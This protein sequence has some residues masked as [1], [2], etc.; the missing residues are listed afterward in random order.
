MGWTDFDLDR[1]SGSRLGRVLLV[2]D[3]YFRGW[4]RLE[5]LEA[6]VVL[7]PLFGPWRRIAVPVVLYRRAQ[8]QFPRIGAPTAMDWLAPSADPGCTAAATLAVK[9]SA[10][11]KPCNQEPKSKPAEFCNTIHSQ[12][13]IGA[14]QELCPLWASLMSDPATGVSVSKRRAWQVRRLR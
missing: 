9:E 2:E 6:I 11:P 5:T 12:A 10:G 7:K 8:V 1:S 13:D 4:S 14:A 3:H